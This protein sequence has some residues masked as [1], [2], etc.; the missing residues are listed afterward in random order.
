MSSAVRLKLQGFILWLSSFSST[1]AGQCL[2]PKLWW[3]FSRM[4]EQ[5]CWISI[6]A[7]I[8]AQEV[9]LEKRGRKR[10]ATDWGTF[11]NTGALLIKRAEQHAMISSTFVNFWQ[12]AVTPCTLAR[13]KN[14]RSCSAHQFGIKHTQFNCDWRSRCAQCST[15][16][17]IISNAAQH[18][19]G[20]QWIESFRIIT[21]AVQCKSAP[22]QLRELL[23]YRAIFSIMTWS[24]SMSFLAPCA[25][26]QHS[27]FSGTKI[28]SDRGMKTK[29]K[30][31]SAFAFARPTKK[32]TLNV[33]MTVPIKSR[34]S[35]CRITRIISTILSM[36]TFPWVSLHRHLL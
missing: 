9:R 3:A 17:S 30:I 32:R 1:D 7:W 16:Q 13:N 12:Y 19:F 24:T 20:I 2:E 10:H 15:C 35:P 26:G 22:W 33:S 14:R 31:P 25:L 4:M 36:I 23:F 34:G 6:G 28:S 18:L 8:Q 21:N 27:S 29:Y 11:I 5:R